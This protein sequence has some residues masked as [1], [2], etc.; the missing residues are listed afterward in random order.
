MPKMPTESDSADRKLGDEWL[1][2]NGRQP[3]STEADYRLF[4]W[5]ATLATILLVGA[6]AVFLWLIYPRL[7]RFG[8]A[9]P[10]IFAVAFFAF[11]AAVFIWLV[12]FAWSAARGR[13]VAPVLLRPGLV[14]RLL[15]LVATVGKYL[16]VSTERLTNS[17]LKSH[18]AL[19]GSQHLRVAPEQLLVLVPRCLTKENNQRLRQ[20]RDRYGFHLFTAGGGSDARL[21]IREVKPALIVA[22]ACERDL[23]S[24]FREV[25]PSI[26]VIGFPNKRPEGPC[27]NTCVDLT[28]IEQAIV[29]ALEPVDQH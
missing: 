13:L 22:I 15:T 7:E 17:F 9:V 26:P 14:N 12:L 19:L 3:E 20:L 27:K 5:I 24:G 8:K 21:R 4:L 6:A 25:N 29:A 18:N 2:W 10:L 1:D 28:E 23:L 16:G 11:A